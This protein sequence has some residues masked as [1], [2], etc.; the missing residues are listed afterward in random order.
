[1]P[2]PVVKTTPTVSATPA[3]HSTT[4]SSAFSKP[5]KPATPSIFNI[6][7]KEESDGESPSTIGGL[8]SGFGMKEV[9]TKSII[10]DI[11]PST[12]I[13]PSLVLDMTSNTAAM[14]PAVDNLESMVM[15]TE[16]PLIDESEPVRHLGGEN[17]MVVDSTRTTEKTASA[18]GALEDEMADMS[19][20]GE[21]VLGAKPF[22]SKE[23]ELMRDLPKREYILENA[24]STYLGL[25]DILFAYSYDLR[26]GEGDTTVETAWT[27]C[28]LSS[29]MAAL[30]QFTTLK[31]TL[32]ASVRRSL[33]YPLSRNWNLAMKVLQDVYVIFK[34]GRRGI[35]RALLQ[36][37]DVLDHD[38]V[39]YIYSKM[40]LEDY[41]VWIQSARY[42]SIFS[43]FVT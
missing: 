43:C 35:L 18:S 38:D 14:T 16:E 4:F 27:I 37:K 30:D 28:K 39:Y 5:V 23:Q 11:T 31:E 29:S 20:T 15:A 25:I 41:C 3:S 2:A 12:S 6:V 22:S 33:A 34:L 7:N 24:K 9:S 1:M 40:F 17:I 21:A 8:G 13:T 10:K 32:A 19:L 36:I 42:M 26:V